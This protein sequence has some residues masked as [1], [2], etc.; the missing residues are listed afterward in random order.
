MT[1]RNADRDAARTAAMQHRFADEQFDNPAVESVSL[2]ED[3][4][5]IVVVATTGRRAAVQLA[6][7]RGRW[8]VISDEAA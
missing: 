4:A 5:Q 8:Q 1:L 2:H 3:E 6:K 7:R